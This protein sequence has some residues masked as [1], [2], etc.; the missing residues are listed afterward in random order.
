MS[1]IAKTRSSSSISTSAYYNGDDQDTAD[2]VVAEV[3]TSSSSSSKR[4][5]VPVDRGATKKPTNRFL[6]VKRVMNFYEYLKSTMGGNVDISLMALKVM[7]KSNKEILVGLESIQYLRSEGLDRD[8]IVEVVKEVVKEGSKKRK[9]EDESVKEK[10]SSA[11]INMKTKK[12][13]I[14]KSNV[15]ESVGEDDMGESVKIYPCS[16]CKEVFSSYQALGGHTASHNR[17]KKAEEAIG[18]DNGGVQGSGLVAE[19]C[20][21]SPKSF[22]TS[23]ALMRLGKVGK[24]GNLRGSVES[25]ECKEVFSSSQALGG[26]T[27]SHKRKKKSEE[28]IGINNG[29]G[30]GSGLVAK[31]RK[32][33]HKCNLCP[34]SF[35]TGQALGGHKTSHNEKKKGSSSEKPVVF[36]FDLNVAPV[37]H[38]FESFSSS[39]FHSNLTL[40]C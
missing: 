1:A 40:L 20:N 39:K 36:D 4:I 31:E 32:S 5:Y 26:H 15:L 2:S 18:V 17:K 6:L 25:Y 37:D 13:K 21:L 23:Q 35:P 33:V 11:P 19:G 7:Y 29:G 12:I 28:A 3:L 27:A 22:S 16:E 9:V 30:E 34:R 8:Q 10:E 14:V 38:S 24:D